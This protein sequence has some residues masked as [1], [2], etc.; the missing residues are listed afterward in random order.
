MLCLFKDSSTMQHI[1]LLIKITSRYFLDAILIDS[2]KVAWYWL[3]R[4]NENSVTDQ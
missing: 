3:H 1:K 4:T 2:L